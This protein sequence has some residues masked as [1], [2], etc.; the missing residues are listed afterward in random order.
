MSIIQVRRALEEH[1]ETFSGLP[2]VR[3]DNVQFTVPADK[4]FITTSFQPTAG[5]AATL[6]ATRLLLQGLFLIDVHKPKYQGSFA[7]EDLAVDLSEHFKIG[8]MLS[9][10]GVT[11]RVRYAQVETPLQTEEFYQVP[12]TIQWYSYITI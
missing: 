5:G 4:N 11:V 8:T 1:L 9:N 12:V 10:G 6:G 3:Y 2:P 7:A